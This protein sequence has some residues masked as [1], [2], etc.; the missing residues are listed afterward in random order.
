MCIC[1]MNVDGEWCREMMWFVGKWGWGWV[2][3]ELSRKFG[4]C[5]FIECIF[6]R[7]YFYIK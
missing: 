6:V 3:E 1:V 7:K 4:W 2:K 5:M